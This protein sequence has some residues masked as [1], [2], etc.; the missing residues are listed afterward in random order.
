MGSGTNRCRKK[1]DRREP[2]ILSFSTKPIMNSQTVMVD[3]VTAW[4]QESGRLLAQKLISYGIKKNIEIN[5]DANTPTTLI[6]IPITY[7]LPDH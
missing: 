4:D 6:M 7:Q 1:N 5:P 2:G 3:S